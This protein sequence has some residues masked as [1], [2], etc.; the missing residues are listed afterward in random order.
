MP[1]TYEWDEAKN[2]ANIAKHR[3]D[4]DEAVRIFE[5]PVLENID[6]RRDYGEVRIVAFGE[7]DGRELTVVY[8]MRGENP[9]II[10]AR[11]SYKN[12]RRTYRQV[13]PRR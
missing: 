6:R 10:S 13:Y 9:R 11:R 7:V 2:A 1:I 4:F 12:E 5:G 8:T 3:I